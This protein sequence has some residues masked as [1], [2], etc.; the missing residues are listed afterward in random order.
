MSVKRPRSLK[1]AIKGKLDSALIKFLPRAFDVIGDI[2][3]LDIKEE[4]KENEMLIA[5]TLLELQ[6]N[7]KVVCKKTGIH[8]GT[9]R[10]QKLKILAG[11]KRKE[12][13]YKEN[14][15]TLCLDVE[16]VYFSPRSSSERARIASLVKKKEFVLVMFSGCGPFPLVILRTQPLINKITSIELNPVAIRYHKKNLILNKSICKSLPDYK[17]MPK[18]ISEKSFLTS[19]IQQKIDV[20]EGDVRE[21]VP[22]LIEDKVY[23]GKFDRILMPLPKSAESFLDIALLASRKDTII[24]FYDFLNEKDFDL[25]KEKIDKACRSADKR[26]KILDLVKCGQFSP[27]TYRICVD[28]KV[29]A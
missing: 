10:T 8:E 2:A 25:A 6:P 9:F 17:K 18:N 14:N 20:I 27:G 7:I 26:Y 15:I 12:T 16:Q 4:L 22:K 19:L 13:I 23:G 29:L 5:D 11:E 21:I 28:F 1:E 24:H 3:I